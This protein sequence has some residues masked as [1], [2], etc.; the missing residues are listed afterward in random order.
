MRA[1]DLRGAGVRLGWVR[2]G[3][4]LFF[5][6]VAAR[7]AHLGVVDGRGAR[8][9]VAQSQTELRLPP[10]RGTLV[11]RHGAELALSVEAPSVYASPSAIGDVPATA[12]ALAKALGSD[13][14]RIA[15]RL[16]ASGS[17][18]YIARW[19]DDARARRVRALELSGI[20]IVEEPR[21]VYPHRELAAQLIGFANIDGSGVRGI[22]QQED[23]WLRGRA[24]SYAVERDARGHLLAEAGMDPRAT[25]GGDV[26]LT[27]DAAFQADAE[28][29]LQDSMRETR[30]RAGFVLTLDPRTGDVLSLAERPTFDPNRFREE[31]FADTRSRAFLDAFEPGSTFKVFLIASALDAAAIRPSDLFDCEMGRFKVPGKVIRDSHPHGILDV[32]AILRVSS[33]IGAT[34]I[35][36]RL[37]AAP[38]W[39]RLRAFGFG[40]VT[41]SGFPQESTG[42][43]RSWRAWR[44]VDEANIAF[45][46]GVNVTGVQLAAA[47]GAIANGGIWNRPR[48]V[49]ARRGP[50]GSWQAEPTAPA[51]RVVRAEV[52]ATVLGMMEGVV[53]PGGTGGRAALPGIRVAGKT[54]T[55]QK[56]DSTTGTYASDR[57]VAWFVG[58]APADDPRLVVVAALDDP[59]G[60]AHTGGAVSAPLFAKVATAQLARLGILTAPEPPSA[61]ATAVAAAPAPAAPVAAATDPPD[62]E[63]ESALAHE[64]GRV[65]LPDFRGLSVTEVRRLTEGS[66]IALE[67]LGEGR[68]V[69][70][71]PE[72]GTIVAGAATRVRIHFARGAGEG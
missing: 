34:K 69:S 23:E 49:A 57:Y 54:G 46:Q 48:L 50:G 3:L 12:R 68:A 64:G 24:R 39:D 14:R 28:S 66:P 35:A 40:E 72:P 33:N 45:G 27:L 63:A 44:P 4:L 8:R 36:Y 47:A 6:A 2:A 10:E 59:Q 58:I 15:A 21:R 37:G 71:E 25:A 52:A 5:L 42:L 65:L 70:Q 29:A 1:P 62:D 53:G 19:I 38:Y 7:A 18:V 51:R 31:K 41:G 32:A 13:S 30:A 17:F 55:A 43:L 22:E 16:R 56:L 11:D 9:G 20:G 60:L 26:A 61:P 67:I